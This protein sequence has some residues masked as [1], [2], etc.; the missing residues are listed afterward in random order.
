MVC[1]A[2]LAANPGRQ[3]KVMSET[4]YEKRAVCFG[5]RFGDDGTSGPAWTEAMHVLAAAEKFRIAT[6]EFAVVLNNNGM[7]DSA[8]YRALGL[9]AQ[10]VMPHVFALRPTLYV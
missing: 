1:Y 3:E 2:R 5:G 7:E 9:A 6:A 4:S 10:G 8:L